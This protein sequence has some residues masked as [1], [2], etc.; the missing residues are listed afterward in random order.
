VRVITESWPDAV[1]AQSDFQRFKLFSDHTRVLDLHGLN[2]R[3]IA[4][5]AVEGRVRHGKYDAEL[6]SHTDADVWIWGYRYFRECPIAEHALGTVLADPGL[7]EAFSGYPERP[8]PEARARMEAR[9]TTASVSVCGG[10]YNF[11]VRRNLPVPARD[12]LLVHRDAAVPDAGACID[13]GELEARAWLVEGWS[14][15]ERDVERSF[16]WSDGPAATLRWGALP[17][18]RRFTL[19]LEASGIVGTSGRIVQVEPS[20]DGAAGARFPLPVGWAAHEIAVPEGARG[21]VLRFDHT[22]RP[23]ADARSLALQL[24]RAC[25]VPVQDAGATGG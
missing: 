4:H 7:A 11:L 17:A 14:G 6:A 22:V 13:A 25:L 24:D 15:D 2:D 12:D 18:G 20:F 23:S 19:V 5:R 16:V 8:G 3:T 1:V 10:F 21:V 9:F